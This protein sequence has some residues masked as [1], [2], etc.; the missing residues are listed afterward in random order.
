MDRGCFIAVFKVL[1]RM[2][3]IDLKLSN[4]YLHPGDIKC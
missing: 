1:L 3:L 4:H 2:I